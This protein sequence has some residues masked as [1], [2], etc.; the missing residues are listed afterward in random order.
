MAFVLIGLVYSLIHTQRWVDHTDEVIAL[1]NRVERGHVD[2]VAG[3]RGY[4][5]TQDFAFPGVF[6]MRR[7]ELD[8][9][10]Q[11]LRES[12]KDNPDQER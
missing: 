4:L 10:L 9:D 6:Q 3:Y 1:A 12:V 7:A 2:L 5:L 8:R 11:A